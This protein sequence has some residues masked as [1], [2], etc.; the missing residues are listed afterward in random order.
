[1]ST[2]IIINNNNNNNN[3]TRNNYLVLNAH[4]TQEWYLTVSTAMTENKTFLQQKLTFHNL[5]I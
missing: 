1:M 2:I 3:I 4:F 5:Q